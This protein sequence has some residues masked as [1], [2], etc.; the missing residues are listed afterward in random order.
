M[1]RY[2]LL[3]M[4]FTF[5]ISAYNAKRISIRDG[6][7]QNKNISEAKTEFNRYLKGEFLQSEWKRLL[8]HKEGLITNDFLNETIIKDVDFRFVP[9]YIIN[10]KKI[11]EYQ[12]QLDFFK[13]LAPDTLRVRCHLIYNNKVIGKAFLHQTN[14]KW[15]VSDLMT[16]AKKIADYFNNEKEEMFFIG[17]KN[18]GVLYTHYFL[19]KDEKC[20]CI[21]TAN[22]EKTEFTK[23]MNTKYGSILKMGIDKLSE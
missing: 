19:F 22:G 14:N 5:S 13:Y 21:N 15:Q 18:Q 23:F 11:L 8:I 2:V 9:I 1:K 16:F 3:I 6:Y 7:L 12:D 17:V 10:S 20:Y 4:L